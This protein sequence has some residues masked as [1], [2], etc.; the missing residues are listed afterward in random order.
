MTKDHRKIR[1]LGHHVLPPC[2]GDTIAPEDSSASEVDVQH[3]RDVAQWRKA[4]RVRLRAARAAM[5]V[6]D[7][8]SVGSALA[9]HLEDLLHD[10]FDSARGLVLAGYWPIKGEPDLRPLMAS[11]HAS[12]TN[13]ALPVVE[14]KAAPLI[15]RRWIPAA[16]M[17]R[18]DWNIP[19]PPP[20]AQVVVPNIVLAPLVGWDLEGYRLG[21]GGG[22]FDRTLTALFPRP[23]AIGVGF[24]SAQLPTIFPQ[25]HDVRLDVILSEAGLRVSRDT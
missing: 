15:F 4:E 19:V 14:T 21:Y 6:F 3:A 7:R 16:R 2:V 13:I 24:E 10:R 23:F 17:V 20:D 1:P 9:A 12:G 8:K 22:Y 11:L 5:S 18:G 25:S